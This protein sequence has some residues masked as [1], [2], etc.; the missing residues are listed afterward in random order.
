LHELTQSL[1]ACSPLDF[2][3]CRIEISRRLVQW[4]DF[5]GAFTDPLFLQKSLNS[6]NA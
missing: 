3:A 5:V 1:P 4:R 6:G 2:R